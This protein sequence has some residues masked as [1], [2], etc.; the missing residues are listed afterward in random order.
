MCGQVVAAGRLADLQTRD[1]K[2]PPSQEP[3]SV[4]V[5]MRPQ[6]NATCHWKTTWSQHR[7]LRHQVA[8]LSTV[9]A[10]LRNTNAG[11]GGPWGSGEVQ[12]SSGGRQAVDT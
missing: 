5:V 10:S 3:A 12:V 1:P 11:V 2:S 4:A 6:Q 7:K 9:G 8:K